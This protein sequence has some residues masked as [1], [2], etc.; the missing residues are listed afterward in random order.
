MRQLLPLIEDNGWFFDT[1]LLVIAERIGLRIHEVPV[2][3]TDDPDSRVDIVATAIADLKG[4]ARLGRGLLTGAVPIAA[5]RAQVDRQA[6]AG[7]PE[8]SLVGRPRSSMAVAPAGW[9]TWC[10]ATARTARRRPSTPTPS[11]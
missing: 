9:N 3:W 2:D 10:C 11:S 6:R 7:S 4:I 5:L 1:E 8:R